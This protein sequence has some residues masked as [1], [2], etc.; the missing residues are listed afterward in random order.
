MDDYDWE[1]KKADT[2]FKTHMVAGSLAGISEHVF[3]LPF[4]N[5]K[6]HSQIGKDSSL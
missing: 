6:T 1:D 2:S 4:D 3:M 5:V